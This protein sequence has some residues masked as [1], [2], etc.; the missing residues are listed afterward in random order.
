MAKRRLSMADEMEFPNKTRQFLD[1]V[2]VTNN[3]QLSEN[4][5]IEQSL[6]ITQIHLAAHQ[7]RRYFS[8]QGM[9]SLVAS[10]R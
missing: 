10:I 7:P 9:E 6:L 4:E 1:L 2:G 5:S 3:P 8:I